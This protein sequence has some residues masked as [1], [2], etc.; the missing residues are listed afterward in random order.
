[1]EKLLPGRSSPSNPGGDLLH[2]AGS[3]NSS[4]L[5]ALPPAVVVAVLFLSKM[6]GL[7]RASRAVLGGAVLVGRGLTPERRDG[8]RRRGQSFSDAGGMLI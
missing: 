1:M 3:Y 2:P 6:E 4:L 8:D 5:A 7:G